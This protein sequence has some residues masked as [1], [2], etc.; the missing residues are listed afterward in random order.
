MEALESLPELGDTLTSAQGNQYFLLSYL[1]RG[2][3]G[4]VFKAVNQA[5]KIIYAI[6]VQPP[7]PM[8]VQ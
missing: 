6:K 5:T 8:P 3:N 1:G 7:S 2:T 4:V